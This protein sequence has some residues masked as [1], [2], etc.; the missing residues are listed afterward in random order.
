M[1]IEQRIDAQLEGARRGH[2]RVGGAD[3]GAPTS[4]APA[5]L[6][7]PCALQGRPP[8]RSARG[9]PRDAAR[10]RR[11]ARHRAEPRAARAG[12]GDPSPGSALASVRV[13]SEPE[14]S[15]L[16]APPASRWRWPRSPLVVGAAALVALAGVAMAILVTPRGYAAR[17]R[18][19][20]ICAKFPHGDSGSILNSSHCRDEDETPEGILGSQNQRSR[21]QPRPARPRLQAPVEAAPTPQAGRI[22]R[23]HRPAPRPA[24]PLSPSPRRNPPRA[25]LRTAPPMTSRISVT[26]DFWGYWRPRREVAERNG[27]LQFTFDPGASAEGEG[28]VRRDI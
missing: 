23:L 21:P 4:R 15:A 11:G 19:A 14:S 6:A 22:P 25:L 20:H 13:P 28:L 3:R 24:R 8:G 7:D 1:V 26:S 16:G 2:P 12:A 5:R 9:L 18:C 17:Q 27:Q 10:A